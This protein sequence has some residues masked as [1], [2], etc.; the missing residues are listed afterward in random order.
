MNNGIN[1]RVRTLCQKMGWP[2]DIRCYAVADVIILRESIVAFRPDAIQLF[3]ISGV[4]E[5]LGFVRIVGLGTRG[6]ISYF[7]LAVNCTDLADGENVF[8]HE[9]VKVSVRSSKRFSLFV[10]PGALYSVLRWFSKSKSHP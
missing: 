1:Q 6:G 10:L 8:F 7:T 5:R 4:D 9:N 3:P 2:A